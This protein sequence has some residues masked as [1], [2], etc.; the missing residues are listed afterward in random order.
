MKIFTKEQLIEELKN[1]R[2]LGWIKNARPGNVGGVGNTVEDILGIDE[3]NLPIPNAA[4]GE[5]KC[6]RANTSSLTTLFHLEPS[7]KAIKFV[8]AIF[9]LQYGWQH[10]EAG[11]KYSD[12]EMSFRQTIG[13]QNR[14]DRGFKVVIDR[15]QSFVLPLHICR[16]NSFS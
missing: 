4:E 14:S 6:Q 2:R 5:L 1:L 3:N 7:P 12:T 11:E 10:K 8:P 15:Q 13:G 9:L 16:F